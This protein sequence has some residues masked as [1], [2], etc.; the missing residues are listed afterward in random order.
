MEGYNEV[1]SIVAF[2]N[3]LTSISRLFCS[4]TNRIP[5]MKDSLF[6]KVWNYFVLMEDFWVSSSKLITIVNPLTL[7]DQ[8][9]N[10]AKPKGDKQL[11][12]TY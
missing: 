4:L 6:T 5:K 10:K 11:D 9:G 2:N 3:G 1:V 8:R 7:E 12:K